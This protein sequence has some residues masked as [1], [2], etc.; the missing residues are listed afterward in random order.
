MKLFLKFLFA[1][2]VLCL[3]HK[4]EFIFIPRSINFSFGLMGF[5]VWFFNFKYRKIVIGNGQIKLIDYLKFYIPAFLIS[6]F[7]YL[8]HINSETYYISYIFSII[9]A[10]FGSFLLAS[11]SYKIYGDYT[12]RIFFKYLV[13]AEIIYLIL[14]FA[15]FVNPGVHDLLMS[16][17]RIDEIAE[18]AMQRTEGFRIQGYGASFYGAGLVNGYFLMI[19]AIYLSMYR[20][21]ILKTT[22]M[23]LLYL[24][25]AA[26]IGT[27][28]LIAAK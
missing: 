14:S 12:F 7:T 22:M 18:S 6:I 19:L 27:A 10:Y 4:P 24:I 11:L 20:M 1:F 8:I 17:V 5:L 15:M 21:S 23:Y 13:L 16:L 25:V 28:A 9:L 26:I 3:I 2:V